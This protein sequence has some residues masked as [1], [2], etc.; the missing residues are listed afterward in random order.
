MKKRLNVNIMASA[1]LAALVCTSLAGIFGVCTTT[2]DVS[3]CQGPVD[4]KTCKY[5]ENPRGDCD[6][7]HWSTCWKYTEPQNSIVGNEYEARCTLLKNGYVCQPR[8][9]S[10]SGTAWV[11]PVCY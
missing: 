6:Y 4:F 9:E 3:A 10:P 1:L 7:L 5:I 11:I 2:Y 8:P